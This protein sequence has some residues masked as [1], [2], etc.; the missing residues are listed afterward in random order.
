[1]V[2]L[3]QRF[4]ISVVLLHSAGLPWA[5]AADNSAISP[6]PAKFRADDPVLREPVPAAVSG[7]QHR[8]IDPL[9]DFLQ[10]S[11]LAGRVI[12]PSIR[13]GRRTVSVNT[14][15]G[16]PDSTWFTNRHASRRMSTDELRRGPGNED[17]PEQ[18][19]VWR[20]TAAKS[21][22][23]TPGF[24]IEDSRGYRYLLKLDPP[25]FQELASGADMIG[26][27]MLYALGYNTPENYIVHFRRDQL[28]VDPAATYRDA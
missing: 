6:T 2:S 20:V 9:Y 8:S 4:L 3:S 7:V 10:N 15:G 17:A 19:G 24:T 18:K 11:F 13:D 22:G 26:S 16:V 27:K 14:L 23:V 5:V 21:D 12:D 1:M 25:D 28:M